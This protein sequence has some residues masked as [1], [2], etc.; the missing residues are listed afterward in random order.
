[1]S[2]VIK[3]WLQPAQSTLSMRSPIWKTFNWP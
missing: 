2:Q 1:M 3:K